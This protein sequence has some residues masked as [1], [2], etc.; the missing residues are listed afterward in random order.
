MPRVKKWKSPNHPP[1][2]NCE[3]TKWEEFVKKQRQQ[4]R[5]IKQ[6]FSVIP[7]FHPVLFKII[8]LVSFL[9]FSLRFVKHFEPSSENS[10]NEFKINTQGFYHSQ[11]H[12][13]WKKCCEYSKNKNVTL[14]GQNSSSILRFSLSSVAWHF[15]D[16]LNL[17]FLWTAPW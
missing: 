12:F 9:L 10:K 16:N 5:K 17:T 3:S 1:T 13:I 2:A 14:P 4:S 15:F 6:K 11:F 8:M 7:A